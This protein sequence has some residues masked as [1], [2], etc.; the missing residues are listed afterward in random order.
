MMKARISCR[1]LALFLLAIVLAGGTT[2]IPSQVVRA[3]LDWEKVI[4]GLPRRARHSGGEEI[5]TV[6]NPTPGQDL[7]R[8]SDSGDAWERYYLSVIVINEG[9]K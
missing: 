4:A 3:A 1:S 7:W 6:V 2:V 8:S 9:G 5:P